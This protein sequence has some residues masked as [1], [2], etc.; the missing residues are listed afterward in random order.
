M[1]CINERILKIIEYFHED[2][3]ENFA[4]YLNIPEPQI[5]KLLQINEK[6]KRYPRPSYKILFFILKKYPQINSSWLIQGKG[7]MLLTQMFDKIGAPLEKEFH[8]HLEA[9]RQ[10]IRAL[11]IENSRL[12]EKIRSFPSLHYNRFKIFIPFFHLHKPLRVG[13]LCIYLFRT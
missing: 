11:L 2:S 7:E 9:R 4:E 3:V 5:K 1:K 6:T 8:L 13:Y 10:E 12:S